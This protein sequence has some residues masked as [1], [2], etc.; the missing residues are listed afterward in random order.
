MPR[1]LRLHPRQQSGCRRVTLETCTCQPLTVLSMP[2]C[3]LA[4]ET[5]LYRIG[6]YNGG[7]L[8]NE[9]ASMC[10]VAGLCVGGCGAC[11]ACPDL[12]RVWP[13]VLVPRRC[14][15][16]VVAA[17]QRTCKLAAALL[18]SLTAPASDACAAKPNQPQV[19]MPSAGQLSLNLPV[20]GMRTSVVS[21]SVAADDV[22][23]VV[24]NSPANITRVQ[25]RAVCVVL[26]GCWPCMPCMRCR[27]KA[28][29]GAA[30]AW[31][32]GLLWHATGWLPSAELLPTM[33]PSRCA[34]TEARYAAALKPWS[35]KATC[36]V[37]AAGCCCGSVP[38]ALFSGQMQAA[39]AWAC[40]QPCSVGGCWTLLELAP[41]TCHRC[42]C[43]CACVRQTRLLAPPCTHNCLQRT[44]ATPALCP[45][46][47]SSALPSAAAASCL[48]WC[49]CCTASLLACCVVGPCWVGSTPQ[50]ACVAGLGPGTCASRTAPCWARPSLL[51]SL[52]RRLL[53]VQAQHASI[54]AQSTQTLIFEL[55]METDKA[56]NSSCTGA[57]HGAAAAT[58]QGAVGCC[59]GRS[60]SHVAVRSRN[61]GNPSIPQQQ[62][63]HRPWHHWI[64]PPCTSPAVSVTDSLGG[65]ASTRGFSFY[66]NAT[67]YEK[68]PDES[69]VDGN[70]SRMW[71]A[72][73]A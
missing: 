6:R 54:D 51:L 36:T 18:H 40:W 5:P 17:T 21:L 70:A 13:H 3:P 57:G 32:A 12:P 22:Q 53:R 7:P 30:A 60:I 15:P 62:G 49:A 10:R 23:F 65:V 45:Q 33:L 4:G 43:C 50:T 48:S 71:R 44:S 26:T 67:Q 39:A 1:A 35:P 69:D 19:T 28:C 72:A 37:C 55:R 59:R 16:G 52:P 56:T 46:A 38:S 47:T 29:S 9:Q 8:N 42:R 68:P 11:C 73:C 14:E 25:A 58:A 41:S 24:N 61:C 20:P 31:P 66:T 63:A 2:P 64:Y 34:H 27:M